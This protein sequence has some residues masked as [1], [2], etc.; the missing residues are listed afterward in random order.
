MWVQLFLRQLV[1]VCFCWAQQMAPAPGRMM[2]S[3]L[4][5]SRRRPTNR[6][7]FPKVISFE[8]AN[9]QSI[10]K[11]MLLQELMHFFGQLSTYSFRGGDFVDRGLTQATHRTELS[12]QQILAVLT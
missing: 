3:A 10:D 2:R 6:P 8:N 1:E 7:K 9:L 4:P 11:S 12:Q 5:G